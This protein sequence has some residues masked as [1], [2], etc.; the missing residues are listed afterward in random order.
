MHYR[1][2]FL[3]LSSAIG[4]GVLAPTS[5]TAQ[6]RPTPAPSVSPLPPPVQVV[7]PPVPNVAPGYGAPVGGALPSGDLVGVAQEPFVGI[8]LEDAIAMALQRNTDLAISQSNARIANYQI[9]AAQGAYDLR[10]EL[11]PQ[12]QHSVTPSVSSLAA[13]P[14]GGPIV[15]DS[16]GATA[17]FTGQTSGGG[18]YSIGSS[19]T[20]VTSNST[21]NSFDPFYE[22]AISLA[23]TQ[24]LLRNAGYN[25]TRRQL[26]IARANAQGQSDVLLAQA[27]QT[28]ADVSNSYW[29]LVAAWRNV[30]IQEE[31]LR[32]AQAQ[33]SS[34]TRLA[35]RGAVAPVDIVESNTQVEVFQDN[36]FAAFQDV[37][38]LQ[39]QLKG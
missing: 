35:A 20:R 27:S 12:F 30:G 15:Q 38:R 1:L 11:Q 3:A 13:G 31:G 14:N 5:A 32:Q 8:K 23:F 9:V 4:L 16:A 19:A 26:D 28:I 2:L 10:F 39:T 34:N 24:P 36:V 6:S 18:T 17:A 25:D 29:D 37:Q 33:A 22:T 21:V 7:L